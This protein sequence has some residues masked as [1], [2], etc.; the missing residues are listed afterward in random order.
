MEVTPWYNDWVLWSAVVAWLSFIM[1]TLPWITKKFRGSKLS[2]TAYPSISLSH[3]IGITNIQWHLRLEN[4]G[5]TELDISNIDISISDNEGTINVPGKSSYEKN[6]LDQSLLAGFRLK[7]GEMWQGFVCF[8]EHLSI[9]DQREFRNIENETRKELK[10][11][12]NQEIPSVLSPSLISR[13]TTF[14]MRMFKF[15]PRE[16]KVKVH[17][18][19]K[20][21]KNFLFPGYRFTLYESD[22]AE[23]AS[24]TSRYF[25][26]EGITWYS[27]INTWLQI[28]MIKDSAQE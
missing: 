9:D 25:N 12:T 5:G 16:Y 22:V 3:K 2:L 10:M 27:D 8:Y 23:Q 4:N 19:T 28:S 24:H 20:C 6:S 15:R 13:I 14:Y 11:A 21:G 7:P 17:I 26:G 1:N 18:R